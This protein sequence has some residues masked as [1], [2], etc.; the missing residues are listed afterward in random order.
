V[1]NSGRRIQNSPIKKIKE[2][3]DMFKG[4]IRNNIKSLK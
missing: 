2:F 3:E 1:G 4:V